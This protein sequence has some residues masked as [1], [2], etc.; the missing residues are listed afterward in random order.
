[1]RPSGGGVEHQVHEG[2][3]EHVHDLQRQGVDLAVGA[4]SHVELRRSLGCGE[5]VDREVRGQEPPRAVAG[6]GLGEGDLP[7]DD[8]VRTA[9]QGRD[10]HVDPGAGGVQRGRVGDVPNDDDGA[11]AHQGVDA[12]RLGRVGRDGVTQQQPHS[13]VALVEQVS[14]DPVAEHAGGA[15]DENGGGHGR[16]S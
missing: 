3:V 6:R 12:L 5:Q 7:V 14:R 8:D 2:S 9:L 16:S 13:D 11:P 1:M 4:A 15:G 10:D